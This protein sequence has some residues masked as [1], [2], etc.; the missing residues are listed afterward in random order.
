MTFT[1][2]LHPGIIAGEITQSV[3]FWHTP[4]VR[5]GKR[6][7]LGDGAVEVTRVREIDVS[8]IT[9]RLAR[10]SGFEGLVDMLKIARHGA[11]DRVFLVDFEYHA[12]A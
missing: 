10:S 7:R 1:K 4:R 11:S 2:R 12:D 8:D 3:R 9:T 6:Y 5:V